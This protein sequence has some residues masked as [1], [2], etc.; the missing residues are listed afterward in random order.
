MRDPYLCDDVAV[1]RNKLGI[2]SQALLDEAEADYVV[3]RLNDLA[4]CGVFG[5]V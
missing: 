5:F 3:Y 4:I 1:L 2:K